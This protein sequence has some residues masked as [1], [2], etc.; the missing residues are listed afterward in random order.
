MK[1]IS[2]RVRLK[3]GGKIVHQR[4]FI[5][6]IF[7]NIG[8]FSRL[9][10]DKVE[11]YRNNDEEK[12]L[13]VIELDLSNDPVVG[14]P[15]YILVDGRHRLAADYLDEKDD[16]Y[17]KILTNTNQRCYNEMIGSFRNSDTI[18]KLLEKSK[19]I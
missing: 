7:V 6:D 1:R 13:Q 4:V 14:R 8:R 10:K 19:I 17:C 11:K 9:K 16:A 2:L 3:Y 5:H 18:D 12:P 15:I